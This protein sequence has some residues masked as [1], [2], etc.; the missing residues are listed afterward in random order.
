M[1]ETLENIPLNRKKKNHLL[2]LFS[3]H[4]DQ[5]ATACISQD[6][7]IYDIYT[8]STHSLELYSYHVLLVL[9]L[10]LS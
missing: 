3:D 9:F 2:G 6:S 7:K 5:C 10:V 4:S 1:L 8:I